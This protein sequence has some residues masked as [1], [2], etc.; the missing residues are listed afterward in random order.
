VRDGR[1][2][3]LLRAEGLVGR[4][5]GQIPVPAPP[6][7]RKETVVQTVKT[8]LPRVS[9]MVNATIAEVTRYPKE[10]LVPEAHLEDDLGIE[11]VKRV[12]ILGVLASRLGIAAP[13]DPAFARVRT[14]GDVVAAAE[15]MLDGPAAPP[16]VSP[17]PPRP[18]VESHVQLAT[19]SPGVTAARVAPVGPVTAATAFASPSV[20]SLTGRVALVIGSA[21]GVA[22][23]SHGISRAVA[24]RHDEGRSTR[25]RLKTRPQR[26][27]ANS[28]TLPGSGT[29]K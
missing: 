21:H 5:M 24:R 8:P 16:T 19:A 26:P 6:T 1:G 23:P 17:D 25:R 13:Q 9:E 15:R 29:R 14:I 11:S 2:R 12:E 7:T 22:R 3:A 4:R 20:G 27:S 10:I 28:D 18:A